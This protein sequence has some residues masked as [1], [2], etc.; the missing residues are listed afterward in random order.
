M[1]AGRL[2]L[3]DARSLPFSSGSFDLAIC[4]FALSYLPFAAGAFAEMARVARC[5]VVSDLHPEAMLKGWTRSFR[6]DG[7]VWKIEQYYH[8]LA[9]L[10]TIARAAGMKLQW[11]VEGAF[12]IQEL[13]LFELAGHGARFTEACRTTAVLAASWRHKLSCD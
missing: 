10:D 13:P 11:T 4:S 12:D 1:I 2:I 6:K 8:G 5:V 7:Q 3:G 9:E